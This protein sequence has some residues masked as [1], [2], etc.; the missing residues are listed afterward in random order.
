[1]IFCT[2]MY[3]IRLTLKFTLF[4]DFLKVVFAV[5]AV[6]NVVAKLAS[7]GKMRGQLVDNQQLT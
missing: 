1:M 7:H 5:H 6:I 4:I 2:C 3:C